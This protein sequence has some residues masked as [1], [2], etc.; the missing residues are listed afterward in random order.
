MILIINSA[1]VLPNKIN[2]H[3]KYLPFPSAIVV[4]ILKQA[5]FEKVYHVDLRNRVSPYLTTQL[6]QDDFDNYLSNNKINVC[7]EEYFNLS[8]DCLPD[9][10]NIK[11]IG[12]SIFSHINYAY[13]L[14]LA[15]Y[16]KLKYPKIKIIFGG[17]FI[18]VKDLEFPTFIDF[19]VKGSPKKP[20]LAIINFILKKE[21]ITSDIQGIIYRDSDNNTISRKQNRESAQDEP[22]PDYTDL[23]LNNYLSFDESSVYNDYENVVYNKDENINYQNTNILRIPYRTNMGCNLGCSFCTGRLIDKLS[24]KDRDK[25][26]NDLITLSKLYKNSVIEI[27]DAS[28][29]S[30][31]KLL[32]EIL[33]ELINRECNISYITEANMYGMDEE[34]LE[35][36]KGSGCKYILWGLEAMSEHMINYYKKKYKPEDA[37]KNIRKSS[38]LGLVSEVGFIYNGPTEKIEDIYAIRDFVYTFIFDDKVLFTFNEFYLEER[39]SIQRYPDRFNI[40]IVERPEK[41]KYY[42]RESIVFVEKD[43]SVE[44]YEKKK[45]LHKKIIFSLENDIRTAKAIKKINNRLF[46]LIPQYVFIIRVLKPLYLF[47]IKL[48]TNMSKIN[49]IEAGKILQHSFQDSPM[50]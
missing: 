41:D 3:S 10:K 47:L 40:K 11:I 45:S 23:P 42:N 36:M 35:L 37:Y 33:N 49:K 43:I 29:N 14:A 26:V 12:F 1:G 46:G 27:W 7:M 13:G 38:E 32:K 2:S 28:F 22:L 21:S 18:T 44:E 15:K 8:L 39:S 50:K 48:K 9:L 19:F 24:F 16:I 31:P 17:G 4:N 5:G 25:V 34:L 20:L 6:V 30:N